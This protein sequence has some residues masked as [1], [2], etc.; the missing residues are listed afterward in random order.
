[1]GHAVESYFWRIYARQ[2]IDLVEE[3]GGRLRAAEIQWSPRD[4]AR[5]PRGWRQAYPDGSFQVVHQGNYLDFITAS[6]RGRIQQRGGTAG[7][8]LETCGNDRR[9]TEG[10]FAGGHVSCLKPAKTGVPVSN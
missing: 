10:G 4:A 5:A 8:P 7:F 1:M 6:G 9:G 3:W 2:E